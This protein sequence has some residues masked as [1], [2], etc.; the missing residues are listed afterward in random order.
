VQLTLVLCG[1]ALSG[2][3]LITC[4]HRLRARDAT[5]RRRSW[6]KYSV[7]LVYLGS[8]VG[9]RGLGWWPSALVVAALWLFASVE[10]V[11]LLRRQ[12]LAAATVVAL[13]AVGL[14]HLLWLEPGPWSEALMLVAVTDSYAQLVGRLI[15]RRPLCPKLSP[16]KTVEGFLGGVVAALLLSLVLTSLGSWPHVGVAV[17][18]AL[19]TALAATLG[20]L[21]FS[22]VKRARRVKDFS[23]ALPGHGGVL[24]RIDSLVFAAPA[25][26]WLAAISAA[27]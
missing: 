16:Q 9:V 1:L 11:R 8:T 3:L 6:L 18:I 4:D 20:D 14:A 17:W 23:Q 15:G 22:A 27:T 7:Y 5:Q 24:D 19:G 10:A 21:A 12:P 25:F 26:Y 2:A 13:I